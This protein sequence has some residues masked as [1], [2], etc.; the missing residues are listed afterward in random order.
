MIEVGTISIPNSATTKVVPLNSTARL[1]VAPAS[2]I[3]RSF[4]A[5]LDRSS[6]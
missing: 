6:R 4:A 5:P 3:A 1:A 2:V